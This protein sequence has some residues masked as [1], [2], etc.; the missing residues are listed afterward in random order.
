MDFVGVGMDLLLA[1]LLLAAL[2]Y[3]V[4]LERR[5]KALRDSQAGFA[6]AV[7]ALDTAAARAEAGLDSLRRAADEAHDGLHDR[8]LKAREL[9]AE[10]ERLI[11][12]A[13]RAGEAAP[14]LAA[15]TRVAPEPVGRPAPMR[16]APPRPRPR[17]LDD[18]LFEAA[19]RAARVSG[20]DR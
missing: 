8:I 4:R 5:L 1:A 13:E 14:R 6:E 20:D 3:G 19:P 11:A 2:A 12:R 18:E 16:P 10:L 17:D 15:P 7:R 9:K